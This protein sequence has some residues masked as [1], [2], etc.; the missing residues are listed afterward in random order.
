MTLEELYGWSAYFR[1]KGEREEKAYEDSM[2]PRIYEKKESKQNSSKRKTE[3]A[4]TTTNKRLKTKRQ[5]G[6]PMAFESKE[7]EASSP[8]SF[9]KN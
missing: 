4:N 9:I 7:A 2:M 3:G 1:L 5:R 8:M 6:G